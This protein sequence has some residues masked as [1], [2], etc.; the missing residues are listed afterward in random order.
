PALPNDGDI[1]MAFSRRTLAFGGFAVALAFAVPVAAIADDAN[2][3]SELK[4]GGFVILLRHGSTF[5]NQS[6]T[7]PAHP[8]NIAAQRNLNDEGK[9]MARNFGTA[10]RQ[11]GVPVGKV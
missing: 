2:L 10:L 3:A 1:A 6:D 5:A 11:I 7:D 8:D 9:A 4:A